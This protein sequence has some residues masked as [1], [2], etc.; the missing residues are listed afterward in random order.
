VYR[1][2]ADGSLASLT[3]DYGNAL[4]YTYDGS[5][6]LSR[7]TDSAGSARYIQATWGPSGR[8]DSLTDS[9][10]RV[11]RYAY[12]SNGT[13]TSYADPIASKDSSLRTTYYTYV[14]GRFGPLLSRIEDRW[15]RTISNLAWNPDGTLASYT[16]GDYNDANPTS[17]TGEKYTYIYASGTITKQNSLGFRTYVP[18][19]AGVVSDVSRQSDPV[20]GLTSSETLPAG[21]NVNY[22]YNARNNIAT[23]TRAGVTW[24]YTYDATYP[25]LISSIL[26]SQPSQWAGWKFD[27]YNGANGGSA[28]ALMHVY[29]VGTDGVTTTTTASYTYDSYGHVTFFSDAMGNVQAYLYNSAMDVISVRDADSTTTYEYDALGRPIA[30]TTPSGHRTTYAYDDDDRLISETLPSRAVSPA[31]DFTTTISYDNYDAA[32]GLV[33]TITTDPNGHASSRGYDGLGRLAQTTDPLGNVTKYTYQYN[34][35]SAIIDAN[36]NT[37]SYSYNSDRYLTKKTLF[38]GTSETYTVNATGGVTG[39]TDRRGQTA[40]YQYDG[41][42]RLTA[43][44]FS[45]GL[46]IGYSYTGQNLTGANGVTYTYDSQWHVASETQAG[47]DTISYTYG[48]S[49]DILASYRVDPPTGKP[50]VSVTATLGY[51]TYGRL[52]SLQWSP[53]SG[54]FTYSYNADGQYAA[55]QFPNGQSRTFAYDTQGRLTSV[56]NLDNLNH[57]LL[58]FSYG[59]DYDWGSQTYA[60]LGKRTSM[61]ISGSSALYPNGTTTYTYDANSQLVGVQRPD[62]TSVAYSYDAIGNRTQTTHGSVTL[63]YTYFQNAAGHNTPRLRNPGGADLAYDANGNL[64]SFAYSWDAANRLIAI[65]SAQYQYDFLNRRN[66]Y[67]PP[68]G[69]PVRYISQSTSTVAERSTDTTRNNDYLFG[70]GVDEPL[71]KRA[72]DGSLQYYLIDGMGSVVA[73][74]SSSAQITGTAT[75]DE[76]GVTSGAPGIFGFT[77]REYAPPVSQ[78]W[79]NRARYY[80]ADWGRFIS[81]DPLQGEMQIIGSDVYNYAANAP[82]MYDDRAGL[83]PCT[84]KMTYG[85]AV[86]EGKDWQQEWRQFR[87]V[88][89]QHIIPT[90][91]GTTSLLGGK[92]PLWVKMIMTC[93]WNRYLV[94]RTR[95]SRK[96]HIRVECDCPSSATDWDDQKE[97]STTEDFFQGGAETTSSWL[98]GAP[99]KACKHP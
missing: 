66:L 13:L 55:L 69:A 34:L 87:A 56:A 81:E 23:V 57:N 46:S 68:T 65:S 25:D 26:S 20:T 77:G 61:T 73:T 49:N 50:G 58:T 42:G 67:T 82:T 71:A 98:M 54:S 95:W 44:N 78:M 40:A 33:N 84:W 45:T 12:D 79:N 59:Y 89:T 76:W 2:N 53:V 52:S 5:G 22:T 70:A 43:A 91:P 94:I 90:P 96:I 27:Y 97:W 80:R 60:A 85:T 63:P 38:D 10:G 41:F 17:S 8:L 93:D 6:R 62:G 7:V 99:M 39:V 29:R 24:T 47:G 64:T 3:D 16:E 31:L 86:N 21:D 35:P 28:G 37:T 36:G 19:A 14:A 32:S 74:T 88:I 92:W 83:S 48:Y 72:S 51:D 4:S 11:L 18:S 9:A 30:M 1:F 15:H 75:Y